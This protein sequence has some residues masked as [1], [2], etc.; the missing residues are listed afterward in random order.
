MSEITRETIIKTVYTAIKT[1]NKIMPDGRKLKLRKRPQAD[2][3]PQPR[4]KFDVFK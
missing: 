4:P 2:P 1:I 3:A